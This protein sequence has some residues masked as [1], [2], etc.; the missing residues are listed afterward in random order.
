MEIGATALVGLAKF[1]DIRRLG[2]LRST[3]AQNIITIHWNDILLDYFTPNNIREGSYL[4]FLPFYR[5][6]N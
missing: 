6:R 5:W 3:N 4:S 2:T 1:G